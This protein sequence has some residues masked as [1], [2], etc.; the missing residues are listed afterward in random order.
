[1]YPKTGR[2]RSTVMPRVSVGTRTML[3][4]RWAASPGLVQPMKIISLQS[5]LRIP[6]VHHFRPLS[7]S[8]SPSRVMVAE[9]LLAS[10]LDT[11][12]SVIA[13][14]DR[15]VPSSSGTSHSRC[16][17]PVPNSTSSSMLPVSGAEQL[18]ASGAMA[19]RPMISA[20]GA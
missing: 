20:S 1:M 14:Q 6:E 2:L 12:G 19:E 5:L 15:I 9:M 3:W 4:R 8:E 18:T 13:K 16:C 7:T 11:A 17:A 10:E